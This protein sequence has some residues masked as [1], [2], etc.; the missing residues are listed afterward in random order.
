[1]V[2]GLSI[3]TNSKKMPIITLDTSNL[4]LENKGKIKDT[5]KIVSAIGEE[6]HLVKFTK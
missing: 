1:M 4:V 6:E 3:D 2:R 5:Y